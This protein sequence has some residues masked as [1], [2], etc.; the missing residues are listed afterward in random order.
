MSQQK[1]M[2]FLC[3]MV[4]AF[5]TWNAS[6]TGLTF[7]I[8]AKSIDDLNFIDVLK[9]CNQS[10]KR[11]GD[12]CVLLGASGAAH[13][14]LQE[15]AIRK[16]LK[17]GRYS[18]L[19][20]SVINSERVAAALHDANI[21]IIT[22]DSPIDSQYKHLVRAYVGA[23][24]IQFGKDL[25]HLANKKAIESQLVCC[26]T[27]MQ[28]QNL[29]LRVLGIRRELSGNNQLADGVRLDSREGWTEY[30]RCPWYATDDHEQPLAQLKYSLATLKTE[31]FIS[32]A[33]WPLFDL[34][35]Y[36][37][38]V[39]PFRDEIKSKK[40]MIIIGIGT[41]SQ[42]D[43]ESLMNEDLISGFVSIDFPL[44]GKVSYEAMKRIIEGKPVDP[45]TYIP[46]IIGSKE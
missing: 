20:I 30:S 26:M 8:V 35:G 18:A 46:N 16:A 43:A 31:V 11:Q 9:G 4:T 15:M 38:I 14:R 5:M 10:A 22:F 1:I 2:L 19:A 37:K 12:Q 13:P 24:N 39:S 25:A 45:I 6:A 23:D 36:R 3:L 28:D 41:G 42:V 21:P 29:Q 32:V 33:H 34:A 7:G 27:G 44:I 17:S 40:R